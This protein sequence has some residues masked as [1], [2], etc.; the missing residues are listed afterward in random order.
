MD[1]EKDWLGSKG[2]GEETH[3]D[4]HVSGSTDTENTT[5]K[6]LASNKKASNGSISTL[7]EFVH[8]SLELAWRMVSLVPPMVIHRPNH[9]NA[10]ELQQLP[11]KKCPT[12]S[13]YIPNGESD[14]EKA[15]LAAAK[16]MESQNEVH[17]LD[18]SWD[19]ELSPDEY[20]LVYFRPVLYYDYTG[21]NSIVAVVTNKPFHNTEK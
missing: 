4:E 19:L 6:P 2:Q 17:A 12:E 9:I 15:E 11:I 1:K 8:E 3:D 10:K 16:L 21:Q 5:S 18:A 14:T 13:N 7:E 20:E